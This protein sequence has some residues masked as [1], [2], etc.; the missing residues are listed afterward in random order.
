MEEANDADCASEAE[1][2][3]AIEAL[4]NQKLRLLHWGRTLIGIY[5]RFAEYHQP[6]DLYMEAITRTLEEDRR[7]WRP[8]KCS[9]LE[10]LMG[11]MKSIASHWPEKYGKDVRNVPLRGSDLS[12]TELEDDRFADPIENVAADGPTPQGEAAAREVLDRVERAFENDEDTFNVLVLLAQRK[13]ES[14]IASE[15]KLP[16]KVVHAAIQRIRYNAPKTRE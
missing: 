8:A 12:R 4:G 5:G 11:T 6:D 3:S 13:T 14:E 2:R 15:L 1:V 7:K 16:V 9:F 10:H